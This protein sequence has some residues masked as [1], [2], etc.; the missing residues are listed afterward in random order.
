VQEP[1]LVVRYGRLDAAA[2]TMWRLPLGRR[3]TDHR[4]RLRVL[5]GVEERL[6]GRSLLHATVSARA[7]QFVPRCTADIEGRRTPPFLRRRPA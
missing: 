6:P 5:V 2:I 1:P 7:I 3:G 4:D